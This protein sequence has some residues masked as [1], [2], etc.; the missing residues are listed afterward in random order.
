[1][2]AA[3]ESSSAAG[4][5]WDLTRMFADVTAARAELATAVT[6]AAALAARVQR[7]DA[8]DP[9]RLRDLLDEA[10]ALAAVRDVF[11]QDFGYGAL[12]LLADSSDLE[13][14]DLLAECEGSVA[15]I[16]D[17]LRDLSL[18]V[19]ERPDLA[20]RPELAPYRHWL[21]HQA[22]LAATK[23]EA[24][25][26]RAFAA[27]TPTASSAWGRLSQE[28]LTAASVPF[29]A[30]SGAQP[31]GVV[32][33]KLL[34]LHADRDVRRRAAETLLGIY[35]ERLPVVAACLDA[36]ISDRLTED[37]LRG[38]DDPMAA[39]LAADEVDAATVEQL[40]STVEGRTD[41]PARWYEKK[42]IALGL[43]RIESY[44]RLAPVGDP[45]PIPYERAVAICREVFDDLS[46]E[47]GEVAAALFEEK[48]VDAERRPGKDG[49]IFCA[50]FAEDYGSFVFLSYIES[51]FGVTL[52]GHELGHAVHFG[53]ARRARPW[54][55]WT[56]PETAAFLEVPS[57]FAEITTAEYMAAAIGGD[58]GKALLR[59]SL[60]TL[61]GVVY[62]ATAGTRFE[63]Q[64]C[65]RRAA[66]EALTPE[67]VDEMSL[68]CYRV[69]LGPL[70]ARLSAL[71]IPH[72]YV[73][74]FYGY[75][76]VYAALTALGLAGIRR[77]DPEKFGVDYVGMLE[78]SGTGTPA[79]LL[80]RCGLDV[81]DPGIWSRSL[82]E[83][84]RLA[85][86]AW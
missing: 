9:S 51:A 83:L 42:R 46:P 71:N 30:G 1:M 33:L 73:A 78:A 84:E 49:A 57:T 34:R 36:V 18:A 23:L 19:G 67:R 5:R 50:G 44:D 21:E 31:H 45:P 17:A 20:A 47:A 3:T 29:D 16:R 66:G 86:L 12:R 15:A 22:A 14:R 56:E 75:Q 60:D 40:L 82:D 28:V 13:A 62:G 8:V 68:A 85:G 64:A 63:Q 4:V 74:R 59:A 26:E 80:A 2:K 81:E 54:L 69:V 35:E 55:A 79:Q 32:E 7:I 58:G 72:H 39:T 77:D 48:R 65:A 10:S 43:D 76:Y 52:L 53:I 11:H 25:A 37:R 41:I 70:A 6:R 24:S 61:I 27:R 38:R